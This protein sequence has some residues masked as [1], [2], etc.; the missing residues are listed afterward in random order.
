MFV[1]VNY[2]NVGAFEIIYD[3]LEFFVMFK[4]NK[5]VIYDIGDIHIE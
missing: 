1:H 3:G 2:W 5:P 4:E